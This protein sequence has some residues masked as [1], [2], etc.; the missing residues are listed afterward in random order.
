MFSTLSSSEFL[1]Y[2]TV[3]RSPAMVLIFTGTLPNI[4]PTIW[5]HQNNRHLAVPAGTLPVRH[6]KFS[7]TGSSS[8]VPPCVHSSIASH[9]HLAPH[10]NYCWIINLVAHL[11]QNSLYN[12]SDSLDIVTI[13]TTKPSVLR[14]TIR[15]SSHASPLY[16]SRIRFSNLHWPQPCQYH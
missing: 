8:H 3:A 15:A 10:Q 7:M 1:F 12:D 16:F 9:H 5:R 11:R 13:T 14:E 6:H 4:R 2:S